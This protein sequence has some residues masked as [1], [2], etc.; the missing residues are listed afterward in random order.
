MPA[1]QP[2]TQMAGPPDLAA[3]V[4]VRVAETELTLWPRHV[5]VAGYTAR[6]VES[7]RRHIAEL[8]QIG[9]APPPHVPMVYSLPTHVLTGA[10]TVVVPGPQ[11]SGEVEPVL[12][13]HS[14]AW[15]LGVGSDHTDRLL[16]RA[17]I[18]DAKAACPKP[19]GPELVK[20]PE[21]VVDGTSDAIWDGVTMSSTVDGVLYQH[22][23]ARALRPPSDLLPWVLTRAGYI[24]PEDDVVIFAGTLPLLTGEFRYGKQ[25]ELTLAVD[26]AVLRHTYEAQ[27]ATSSDGAAL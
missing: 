20:L 4:I 15:Y 19:I 27:V 7:V 16:E 13:R 18:R 6:D 3:A 12:V 1:D 11:T 9:I 25:W 22:G 21:G 10:T 24:A 8:S 23:S 14:A 26:E 17:D 5:L 2:A